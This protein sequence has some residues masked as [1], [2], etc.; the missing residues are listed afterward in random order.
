MSECRGV[1]YPDLILE[2]RLGSACSISGS[3]ISPMELPCQ[4]PNKHWKVGKVLESL[5]MREGF[6]LIIPYPLYPYGIQTI[7]SFKTPFMAWN[8][9]NSS[10]FTQENVNLSMEISI[11]LPFSPAEW[12]YKLNSKPEFLFHPSL[13]LFP[14]LIPFNPADSTVPTLLLPSA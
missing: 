14:L 12:E 13:E 6:A 9:S 5:W 4:E 8:C 1:Q 2:L 3:V 10:E 11:L 7:F